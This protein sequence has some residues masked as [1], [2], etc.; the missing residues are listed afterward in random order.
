MTNETRARVAPAAEPAQLTEQI[1]LLVD[2][3]TRAF[4]LGSRQA[5][6]A[7]SEGAVARVLLTDAIESFRLAAPEEHR[8]RVTLGRDELERRRTA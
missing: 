1:S 3:E 2:E 6:S 7:R 8:R 4:L 5:D